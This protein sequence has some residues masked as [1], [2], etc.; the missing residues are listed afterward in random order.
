MVPSFRNATMKWLFP[1]YLDK[2]KPNQTKVK[3]DSKTIKQGLIPGGIHDQV[4]GRGTRE[5]ALSLV[6]YKIEELSHLFGCPQIFLFSA[7]DLMWRGNIVDNEIALHPF[8]IRC[9]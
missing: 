2:V 9:E 5:G 6:K 7:F 8:R 4:E 3:V 1:F